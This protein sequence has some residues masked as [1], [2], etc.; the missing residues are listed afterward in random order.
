MSQFAT[1]LELATY[2]H[3]IDDLA[4]LP[5]EFANQANLL[6]EL[7]SDDVE[8]AAGVPIGAT[9]TTLVLAGTWSR[10]LP[11]PGHVRS[12]S[13]VAVNGL[14]LSPAGYT[15]NDRGLIRRGGDFS[16][17]D[18]EGFLLPRE[19]GAQTRDGETWGGPASTV[20]AEVALGFDDVPGFVRSLVLRI[21]A[22][23]LPNP[24]Q[25]TQESLAIYS[26]S[27]GASSN[28]NDGSHVTD[29]ERRRLRMAL[30]TRAGTIT[31]AGR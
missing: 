17:D 4:D 27:Y 8:V 22:R 12:I 5:A 19:Q 30:N 23:T 15:W 28:V 31:P 3:G 16:G 10:D 21:A 25:V 26:A 2:L 1:A 11:I 20:L 13:A 7:I 14:A 29:R 6:L 18:P 9:S 24:S